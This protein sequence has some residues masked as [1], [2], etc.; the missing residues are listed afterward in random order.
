MNEKDDL[1]NIP[2]MVPDRDEVVRHQRKRN[3][4]E[5]VPPSA[6]SDV[7]KVSTWPIRIMIFLLTLSLMGGGALGYYIYEQNLQSLDQA[8][9]LISDLETR[10]LIAG[11]TADETTGNLLERLETNFTQIDRLWATRNR[12]NGEISDFRNQL[13]EYEKVNR[14]RDE[15]TTNNSKLI[16][17]NKTQLVVTGARS[18][19]LSMQLQQIVE[20]V[21]NLNTAFA[22]LEGLSVD[23]Q[24]IKTSLNSGD[25]TMLGVVGRMDAMADRLINLQE[26]VAAIDT[27]R[28]QVNSFL[29]KLQQDIQ[30]VRS[31]ISENGL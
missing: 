21:G 19:E 3:Q 4:Q 27:N 6:Y 26:S 2:S 31:S 20:L 11:D 18:N 16:E 24:S 30:L 23:M 1:G 14:G 28:V 25:S 13:A 15:I 12:T 22:V 17:N 8:N 5:I 7:I 29:N 10:L 9:R